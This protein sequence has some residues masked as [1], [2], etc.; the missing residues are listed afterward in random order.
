M[1]SVGY[2]FTFVGCVEASRVGEV[3]HVI[4]DN[5]AAG[6]V[7]GA[8]VEVGVRSRIRLV[9]ILLLS[10]NERTT[11]AVLLLSEKLGVILQVMRH[12]L[13][14]DDLP[15]VGIWPLEE[16][17]WGDSVHVDCA[18]HVRLNIGRYSWY[19]LRGAGCLLCLRASLLLVHVL[20]AFH[21][22]LLDIDAV[23]A[24]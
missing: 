23:D 17:L 19:P 20:D 8:L 16:D 7:L 3:E 13:A 4:D 2:R 1:Q 18:K 21:H 22:E 5:S 6:A 9:G 12:L 15:E 11:S 24:I 10:L 14:A